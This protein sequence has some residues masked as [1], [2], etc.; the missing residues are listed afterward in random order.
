MQARVIRHGQDGV[1]FS[2]VLPEGLDQNLWDVLMRNASSLTD[3]KTVRFTFRML[4]TVLLLCR[5]C[6]A[7]AHDSIVL[8]GGEL[9]ED[10]TETAFD[11]ATGADRLLE[12]EPGG[13]TLRADPKIVASIMKFG[14]WATD[15]LTKQLWIGLLATSCT[16]EGTD[17][18]NQ[19]FVDLLVN[20]TPTQVL[21]FV[22]ACN[23][24]REKMGANEDHLS[25]RIIFTPQEMMQLTS[26]SDISRIATDIAYLFHAELVEKNFDFTSYLP[27]EN[28]DITPARLGLDLYRRCKG[29]LAKPHAPQSES[30]G[31]QA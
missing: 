1:G 10:R 13:E 8:L 28:F 9:D 31:A 18:S 16:V 26:R 27:T 29:H 20:M 21:I 19:A 4:W 6:H 30:P 3:A 14:S 2:F 7:E 22:T 12:A 5:L 17:S 23:K 24:A 25:S 11:I 15:D